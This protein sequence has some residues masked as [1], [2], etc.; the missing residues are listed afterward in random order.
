M[1]KLKRHRWLEAQI[2]KAGLEHERLEH[3]VFQLG[4]EQ[5]MSHNWLQEVQAG[6]R[7]AEE[8]LRDT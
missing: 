1:A 3:R 6:D 7:I 4:L 2:T 8:M 5:G